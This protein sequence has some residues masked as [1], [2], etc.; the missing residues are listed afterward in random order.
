MLLA[1]QLGFVALIALLCMASDLTIYS[2]KR[3]L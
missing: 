3:L 2:G 1:L